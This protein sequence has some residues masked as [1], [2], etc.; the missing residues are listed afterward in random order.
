MG[1]IVKYVKI[2]AM[3]G[4][5]KATTMVNQTNRLFLPATL[6]S[7]RAKVPIDRWW[8]WWPLFLLFKSD[9]K[10]PGGGRS[11]FLGTCLLRANWHSTNSCL[12]LHRFQRQS[13]VRGFFTMQH[14]VWKTEVA[15]LVLFLWYCR[16][17][18]CDV[19]IYVEIHSW[20]DSSKS[21]AIACSGL[22]ASSVALTSISIWHRQ[23]AEEQKWQLGN[24]KA[25]Q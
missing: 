8:W 15:G 6:E 23:P 13:G 3:D 17:D 2:S 10:P 9:Q 21:L 16:M 18:F 1:S 11:L 7:W 14:H 4:V 20:S 25:D 22:I 24:V 19:R 5:K 12:W